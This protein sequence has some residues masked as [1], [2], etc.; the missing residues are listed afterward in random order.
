MKKIAFLLLFIPLQLFANDSTILQQAFKDLA[1]R[2]SYVPE[3]V[4]QQLILHPGTVATIKTDRIAA[5]N[6][7]FYPFGGTVASA[8]IERHISFRYGIWQQVPCGTI[9]E[10]DYVGDTVFSA[11]IVGL[12]CI[13]LLWALVDRW[14]F[15]KRYRR[16]L[17]KGEYYA[18]RVLS[19][20]RYGTKVREI[21]ATI[22]SIFVI[23]MAIACMAVKEGEPSAS[24][25]A[26]QIPLW[27]IVAGIAS[28][29]LR[30]FVLWKT[31][32]AVTKQD[33][34]VAA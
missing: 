14:D 6:G 1:K 20:Y 4:G 33:H 13:F 22:G 10:P 16:E 7:L 18:E 27:F 24:L 21:A 23:F 26:I 19:S 31:V 3:D 11:W 28:Y 12:F 34:L 8:Y 29:Q 15:L 25:S 9:Y 17:I 2:P 5:V 32:Q 30:R